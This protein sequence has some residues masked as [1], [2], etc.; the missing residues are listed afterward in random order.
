[1]R[2]VVLLAGVVALGVPMTAGAVEPRYGAPPQDI[3]RHLDRLVAAY[4]GVIAAHDGK[5]LVLAD[6]TRMPISDGRTDKTFRELLEEPDI[7]DMFAFRYP[8]G[9][10]FP[11]PGLNDDPGRVRY[12]PLFQKMYGDCR[13]GEVEGRMRQIVWLPTTVKA[14]V[15]VTTVNGVD[16]AL[17]A[18]SRELEALPKELHKYL[19][20]IAGVYACRPIAGTR[21][22]SAHGY[23]AAIDINTAFS[24][25][26]RWAGKSARWRNRIPGEIAEVFERHG[27]IWGAKW[28]HFDTMHFEYRPELLGG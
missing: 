12:E 14:R 2:L 18:V 20:P 4:P 24:D 19:A 5:D 6:G 26:W 23:G 21:Q 17:E 1:M 27:F 3:A 16:K 15:S 22:M 11:V 7:D 13:K 8:P 9:K 10:S 28:H 25:Y